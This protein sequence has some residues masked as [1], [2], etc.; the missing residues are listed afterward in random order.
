M[1]N[2]NQDTCPGLSGKNTLTYEIGLEQDK[3]FWLRLVKSSGGG[4]LHN[5][6]VSVDAIMETL[7]KAATPF[8]SWAVHMLFLRKSINS[9]AFLMAVLKHEGLVASDPKK[10]HAFVVDDVDAALE[11]FR[12]RMLKGAKASKPKKKKAAPRVPKPK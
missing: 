4:F 9:P 12:A 1:Q 11:K 10:G 6:W 7:R 8:T 3:T 2:I 5:D